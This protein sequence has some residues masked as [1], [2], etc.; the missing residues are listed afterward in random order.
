MM[1]Q[2]MADVAVT[3]L[4]RFA[5][6]I[7]VGTVS[8]PLVSDGVGLLTAF[9]LPSLVDWWGQLACGCGS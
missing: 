3:V 5:L 1:M 4:S 9:T 6:G 7:S 8:P 2:G